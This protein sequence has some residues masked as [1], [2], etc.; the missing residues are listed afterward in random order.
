MLVNDRQ[1][2]LI[3]NAISSIDLDAFDVL[4]DAALTNPFCNRITV[5]RLQIAIGKPGPHR[6]AI[7]IS[8]DDL[9]LRVLFLEVTAH[10]GKRA[11]GA[12]G[13]DKRGNLALGLF[14]DFGTGAPLMRATISR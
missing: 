3:R 5:V 9:N 10:A 8:A 2:A 12:D 7:R 1:A 13:C 4:C 11:A 6:R 14:P